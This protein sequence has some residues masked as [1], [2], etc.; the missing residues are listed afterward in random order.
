LRPRGTAEVD[1]RRQRLQSTFDL[2]NGQ[3]IPP[4]LLAHYSR[5][6]CVLVSG[7]IETSVEELV[8]HYCRIRSAEPVERFV[9]QQVGR[10]NNIDLDKLR[11]LVYT[12]N[13]DWWAILE[14]EH[15]DELQAFLSVASTRNSVS[16]GGDTGITIGT[17]CQYFDQVTVVIVRLCE[18]FDP[19]QGDRA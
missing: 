19:G 8:T 10:I 18:L 2:I 9:T 17:V 12:F 16:H 1:R 4:E 6:L 15:P 11:Q 5:Y 14:A 13:P 3:A 7:F